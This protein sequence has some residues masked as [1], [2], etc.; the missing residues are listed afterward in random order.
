MTY[1]DEW[2]QESN[3]W[4]ECYREGAGIFEVRFCVYF[5]FFTATYLIGYGIKRSHDAA[6][7]ANPTSPPDPRSL[8]ALIASRPTVIAGT[9]HSVVTAVVACGI[10]VAHYRNDRVWFVDETDLIKIWQTVGLPISLSYFFAGKN[11]YPI[12]SFP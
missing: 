3:P 7:K 2:R 9:V 4:K 11:D 5:I 12:I 1:F 8:S 10:L 6:V